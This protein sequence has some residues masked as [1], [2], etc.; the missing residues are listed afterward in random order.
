MLAAYGVDVLDP[1]VSPRR[2]WVLLQRLPPYARRGGE[3]WSI[4][5]ELLAGVIDH[6]AGLTYVVLQALGANAQKPQ[7]VPRPRQRAAAA[8]MPGAGEPPGDGSPV[9]HKTWADAMDALMKLPGVS[10]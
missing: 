1:G 5:S 2:L 7:P 10:H 4:E 9:K 8:A 3:S 6:V